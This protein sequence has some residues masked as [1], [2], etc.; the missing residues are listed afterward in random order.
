VRTAVVAL[1]FAGCTSYKADTKTICDA[2]KASHVDQ[3]GEFDT[4]DKREKYMLDWSAHNIWTQPGKDLLSKV[5]NVDAPR[6]GRATTL[7]AAADGVGYRSCG[8]ADWLD[9]RR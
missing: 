1:L 9:A 3:F 2:P 8:F 5:S 6:A 7:R 4:D